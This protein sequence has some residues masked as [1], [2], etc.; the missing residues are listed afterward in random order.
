MNV[1]EI[2]KIANLARLR[3]SDAEAEAFAEQFSNIVEY[4]GAINAID[5]Q[6]VEPMTAVNDH[7]NAFR[8]DV[9][10]ESLTTEEALRNVPKKNEAFIKVP[11][12]LG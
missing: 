5:M 2:H 7:V 1:S 11:K 10:G 8:D 9:V 6:G 12:V 3:F 4:V